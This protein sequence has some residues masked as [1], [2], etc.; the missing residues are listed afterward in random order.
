M[1]RNTRRYKHSRGVVCADANWT[2]EQHWA[3]VLRAQEDPTND[4]PGLDYG[5]IGHCTAVL[6][7]DPNRHE[8]RVLRA[9]QLWFFGY[10]DAAIEELEMYLQHVPDDAMAISLLADAYKRS[11]ATHQALAQYRIIAENEIA[12]FRN[13]DSVRYWQAV[14]YVKQLA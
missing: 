12:D 9:A 8:A 13:T 14:V 3:E 6:L 4:L 1:A 5:I 10:L 11:G 7:K 2:A